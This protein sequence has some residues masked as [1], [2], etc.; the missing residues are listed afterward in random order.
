MRN[1]KVPMPLNG[2]RKPSE[3]RCYAKCFHMDTLEGK[4][5]IGRIGGLDRLRAMSPEARALMEGL[6]KKPSKPAPYPKPVDVDICPLCNSSHCLG[7]N[8]PG[9]TE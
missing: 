2:G 3:D 6:M 4:R 1:P 9:N 7:H 8:P 5:K